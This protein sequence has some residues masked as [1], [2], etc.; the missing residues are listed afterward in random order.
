MARIVKRFMYSRLASFLGAAGWI[1]ISGEFCYEG[2]CAGFTALKTTQVV[3]ATV[4]AML[5][6]T[7]FVVSCVWEKRTSEEGKRA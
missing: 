6:S 3:I 4:L 2:L 5:F 1:W 7:A